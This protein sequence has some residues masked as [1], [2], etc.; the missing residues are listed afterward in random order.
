MSKKDKGARAKLIA[1]PGSGKMEGNQLLEQVT[2]TLQA[3]GLTLDVTL[4][5][6]SEQAEPIAQQAV[7]DGYKIVIAMGGDDTIW[8]VMR[9][10]AGSKAHLGVIAA[11]TENNVARSLGIPE[12]AEAACS[13]IL[14]G[15]TRKVDVGEVKAKKHKKLIFF[16]VVTIGIASELYPNVKDVPK[17]ELQGL[18]DAVL[19]VLH[20]P[21]QPKVYLTL[22]GESK[23][24]V[25]TMLVTVSNMP[26][27]GAHFLVAPDASLDDGLLDIATYPEFTKAELLAYFAQVKEEGRTNDGKVQRYRA[28]TIIIRTKPKMAVLADGTLLGKGKVKIKLRPRALRLIAPKKGVGLEAPP[29]HEAGRDLPAPVSPAATEPEGRS[30][31]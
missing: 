20:Q 16:E 26:I 8:S 7:R 30:S 14:A 28:R 5:R 18:K 9:G 1:N 15:H 25:K 31:G 23:V 6:P 4:A 13:V 22:D 17:G 2:R 19:A 29:G 11:G 27:M 12:D 10:I 24:R 3:R 21:P